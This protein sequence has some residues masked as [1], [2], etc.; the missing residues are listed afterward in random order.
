MNSIIYKFFETGVEVIESQPLLSS[1]S[2]ALHAKRKKATFSYECKLCK[3]I[4]RI[5]QG[6]TSNLNTHISTRNHEAQKKEFD[7]WTL[8]NKGNKQTLLTDTFIAQ[9]NKRARASESI[10][11]SISECSTNNLISMGAVKKI[12]KYKPGSSMQADRYMRLL[13]MIVKCMLPVS[14]VSASILK[15]FV[16]FFI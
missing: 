16:D 5:Q 15:D 8:K 6:V 12:E 7:E 14:I 9:S 1:P 2:L 4:I 11:P 3:K 10:N 13:I